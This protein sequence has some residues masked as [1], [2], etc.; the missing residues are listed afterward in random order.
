MK[1]FAAEFGKP[2]ESDWTPEELL[3]HE[4]DYRLPELDETVAIAL[5]SVLLARATAGSLPIAIEVHV[6]GRLIFRAA[7]PGS[8]RENDRFIAGKLHYV[9]EAD[10]SSLYGSK[11]VRNGMAATGAADT[12]V[13]ESGPFGG[14][15]PL[16]TT[17]GEVAGVAVISGLPE[18]DDHAMILWGLRQLRLPGSE[19]LT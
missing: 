10:H 11:I 7:L 3:L 5:G 9:S 8:D 14:A 18:T 15:F 12:R 16:R 6:R 2:A 4:I 17:S 19:E 13:P 1:H